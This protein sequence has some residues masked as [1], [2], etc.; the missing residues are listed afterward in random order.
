MPAEL[1]LLSAGSRAELDTK[2]KKLAREM[3]L[4]P[5]TPLAEFAGEL[6]AQQALACRWAFVAR[7]TTEA[8]RK[9]RKPGPPAEH[10]QARPVVFMFPGVGDHYAGMGRDLY[11]HEPVFRSTVDHCVEGLEPELGL[12]LRTI[13]YP[14]AEPERK[15]IDLAKLMGRTTS[16]KEIDRTRIAQ[17]LVFAFEYALAQLLLSWNI[18]PS[19]MVGYSIG[20]Y[21]AATLGGVFSLQDALKLVARRASLIEAVPPGGML[22]IMLG[23]GDVAGYLDDD[24]EMAAVDSAQLC[25]VAGPGEALARLEKKLTTSGVANLRAGTRHAFH[26]SMMAPA[27]GPLA[28]LLGTIEL[29]P[30]RIPFLS[31]VTGTWITDEEATSPAYWSRHLQQTVQFHDDLAEMWRL[32][33]AIA[34]EVGAGTMLSSLAAQHP[35]CPRD[36][37][38]PVYAT[39]DLTTLLT[40]VG[41]LWQTGVPVRKA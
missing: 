2:T 4:R 39:D 36:G 19:G 3:A 37:E 12:D 16:V 30:P 10:G 17:P 7:D 41:R 22:V 8:A 27:S 31:N 35:G 34:V 21:V 18:K 32:P 28:D 5:G 40:T 9:L 6:H 25:V 24:V 29:H 13:L 26:S 14:A 11:E 38:P 1:V 23:P 15:G 20:E 33:D